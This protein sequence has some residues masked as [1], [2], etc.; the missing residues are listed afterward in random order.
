MKRVLWKEGLFLRP[1]H[2]QKQDSLWQE[3]WFQ[4]Y[5]HQGSYAY[6]LTGFE[7][8]K[9]LLARGD[10]KINLLAGVMP[11]GVVFNFSGEY[12]LHVHIPAG[13]KNEWVV[14]TLP[15]K[16]SSGARIAKNRLVASDEPFIIQ[17]EMVSD[18]MQGEQEHIEIEVLQPNFSLKVVKDFHSLVGFEI[19]PLFK[20]LEV[21]ETQ[22]ILIDEQYIPSMLL[23]RQ[24]SILTAY[25]NEISGYLTAR[26]LKLLERINDVNQQG[27]A[28]A[29][30]LLLLQLINRYEPLLQ[31]YER[32]PDLHPEKIYQLFLQMAGELR[33]FTSADRGYSHAPVYEHHNLAKTFEQLVQ[34]LRD[35]FN[36]IFDEP[37]ILIPFESYKYNLYLAPFK[38][39]INLDYQRLILAVKADIPSE[40]LRTL[41]PTHV[42]I[43]SAEMI[44]DLV[45]L[46]IP[47]INLDLLPVAP[48]QIPYHSG[49]FYFE[50][51]HHSDMWPKLLES[52]GVAL[53]LSGN[54]PNVDLKLWALKT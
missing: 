32:Q 39:K 4:L 36:Y 28:G 46:Q 40:Q 29:T 12:N 10:L 21:R 42:K 27:T 49:Y 17:T 3:T 35:A 50:L 23:I 22:E 11:S 34:D 53:H 47:G 30:E 48:R 7:F 43:G 38:D 37:A 41:F 25:V 18:E 8:T 52:P 16:R 51:D 1:Q 20:I 31:H 45:N 2:F 33:T 13:T 54:F 15:K 24:S 14:L 26:R 9:T 5:L 6:G 44:R 19:L